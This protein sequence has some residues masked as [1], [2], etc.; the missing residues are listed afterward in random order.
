[1]I[2][3]ARPTEFIATIEH[4]TQVVINL[5]KEKDGMFLTVKKGGCRYSPSTYE[6]HKYVTDGLEIRFE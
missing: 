1:M 5:S 4:M 6:Q 2:K 3:K